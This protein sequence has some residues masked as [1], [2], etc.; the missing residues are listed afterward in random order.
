MRRIRWWP[1]EPPRPWERQEDVVGEVF[2]NLTVTNPLDATKRLDC[3]ALVDTGSTGLVL[4][5]AWR[6]R[7]GALHWADP[8]HIEVADQRFVRGEVAGPVNIQLEGFRR[9]SNEVVFMAMEPDSGEYEPLV[10]YVVLEQSLA[11]V[12]MIEHKVVPGRRGYLLKAAS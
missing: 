2:I 12:D 7:L 10:G 1:T 4:P 6:D 3:R 11:V 9:V 8:I 5:D